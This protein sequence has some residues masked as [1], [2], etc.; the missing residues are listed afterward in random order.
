MATKAQFHP[1]VNYR[2]LLLSKMSSTAPT[3]TTLAGGGSQNQT[4][5]PL[6]NA[7]PHTNDLAVSAPSIDLLGDPLLVNF[8][9]QPFILVDLDLNHYAPE[10]ICGL[11]W[12][13]QKQTRLPYVFEPVIG[14]NYQ[15][16]IHQQN[17]E[18]RTLID[19]RHWRTLNCR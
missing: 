3:S 7:H 18:N 17:N 1:K 8:I 13:F 10:F 5:V 19:F 4:K 12:F 15:Y 14:N 11:L 16:E 2:P 9:E 6:L